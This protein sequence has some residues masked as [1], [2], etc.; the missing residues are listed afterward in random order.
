[1]TNPVLDVWHSYVLPW[2]PKHG[3]RLLEQ[4]RSHK[5]ASI[6]TAIVIVSLYFAYDK[7]ARPPR[8]LRHIPR[9]GFFR[10]LSAVARG[11]MVDEIARDITLPI[12]I[13]AE[14]G[15]YMRF[16][17][18]GWAVHITRPEAAKR[19]L[20]KMDI[21]PKIDLVRQV[22]PTLFGKFAFGDNIVFLNGAH[23][24]AQRKIAS[25]AFNRSMPVQKFGRL[26]Q[27]LFTVMDQEQGPV[28]FHDLAQR[29]TLDAIGI[30]G[31][32]FDFNAT[33][34]PQAEWL[35]R[36]NKFVQA[37]LNPFFIFFPSMD[38]KYVSWFPKRKHVHDELGKF[39]KLIDDVIENK[40]TL[41]KD[42][43][44]SDIPEAER[45]IL[46]LMLEA[47]SAD[48]GRLT[49]EELRS[50]ICVFFLAGHDT[51]SN[52]ISYAVYHLAKNPDLQQKAREEVLRALGDSS[53]DVLP[54]LD[55][56]KEMTYINQIIKETLRIN[57]PATGIVPRRVEED[58][59][60]CGVFLP[61]GTH[62]TLDIFEIHNNPTVWHDPSRFD[63]ER[64]A[65]GVKPT[66][67]LD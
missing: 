40:R 27:K 61:K 55:Q 12:A 60:L 56:I 2:I 43:T 46:T 24:K 9:T 26:S 48:D 63:P 66:N 33:G 5:L 62:I 16:D 6:S 45:D 10:Y 18:H 21:F 23:W 57:P 42:T 29:W 25:P 50:N 36:Y 28:N 17:E 11:K 49:D 47:E 67:W 54:T 8:Y 58:T 19:M 64:F 13:K 15:I 37:M 35:Q 34:D 32:G 7:F 20:L 41:L 59:E 30:N 22:G 38:S 65:K 31:F 3:Q 39:L 53:E 1:M 51:T 4:G 52:A 14:S 44:L